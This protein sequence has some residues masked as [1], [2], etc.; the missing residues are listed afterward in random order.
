MYTIEI[1][2][3]CYRLALKPLI[4]NHHF[5]FFY[6]VD[7]CSEKDAVDSYNQF[8]FLENQVRK[9]VT[10]PWSH[11]TN[12][13]PKR[14]PKVYRCIHYVPTCKRFNIRFRFTVVVMKIHVPQYQSSSYPTFSIPQHRI[15]LFVRL[16]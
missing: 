5:F 14:N 11:L 9:D 1:N 8:L 10:H 7:N 12:L 2:S 6:I 13:T 4:S 3:F 16:K 15:S